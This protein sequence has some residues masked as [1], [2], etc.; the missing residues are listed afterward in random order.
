MQ[1][2]ALLYGEYAD[3]RKR[4]RKVM[5][6]SLSERQSLLD[7]FEGEGM[8][9]TSDHPGLLVVDG[10]SSSTNRYVHYQC[11]V[12]LRLV[13][14]GTEHSLGPIGPEEE[15]AMFTALLER[16]WGM[17]CMLSSNNM[18]LM[19]TR[20][21]PESYRHYLQAMLRHWD[22]L[23]REGPRYA[24]GVPL[25]SVALPVRQALARLGVPQQLLNYV[26]PLPVGG[27]PALVAHADPRTRR[28]PACA[29]RVCRG[30]PAPRGKR[31]V[32]CHGAAPRRL[33]SRARGCLHERCYGV[34]G[35]GG[36]H[37]HGAAPDRQWGAGERAD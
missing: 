12:P 3:V 28:R 30:S 35:A 36:R 32:R 37:G 19:F 20:E 22:V 23:E 24:P 34:C 6:R 5:A 27:L 33:A 2:P 10:P 17:L 13:F 14:P 15:G 16:P 4:C 31:R 8:I 18:N 11:F 7:A 25:W 26:V 9:D 1:V 21:E 29:R